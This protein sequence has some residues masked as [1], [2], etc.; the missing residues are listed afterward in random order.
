MLKKLKEDFQLSIVALFGFC[1]VCAVVPFAIYR[2]STGNFIVGIIDSF[3]VLITSSMVIIA[4]RTG[5]VEQ[6]GR[7]LVLFNCL[8]VL[9]STH[10]TGFIG[11]FWMYAAILSNF[12]LT[13][14]QMFAGV[15]NVITLFIL[16]FVIADFQSESQLWAFL[17][18]SLLLTLL[19]AIVS[20]RNKVQKNSLEKL[21]SIDPLTGAKNRRVM[22]TDMLLAL[23]EN[24]RKGTPM[25]VILMD[26]DHFK[27]FNDR[28]G[29][30][31]GDDIL[32]NFSTMVLAMTRKNDKF[33]RY[34]GEE[35][36]MLVKNS[37]LD[38]AKAIA[39][40]IRIASE[41][42]DFFVSETITVS[43][44]VAMLQTGETC[45]QWVTRADKAMYRSKAL[46]RNQVSVFT[47]ELNTIM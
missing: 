25:A 35:F 32:T 4:I 30:E 22:K 20:V 27:T 10:Y 6:A 46:G 42:S 40:K 28:F 29:H 8:G 43:L 14:S 31:V 37:S 12:Y 39:E 9:F 16:T 19:S 21:A 15:C 38:E 5:R 45:E 47:E 26:L 36:L 13:R 17:I 11:V 24:S 2:F 41:S 34:G 7:L 44:G 3:I 33:Y 23:E 1:A 18:T